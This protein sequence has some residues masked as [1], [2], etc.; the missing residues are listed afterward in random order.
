MKAWA[1]FVQQAAAQEG[2]RPFASLE[3]KLPCRIIDA[4]ELYAI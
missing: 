2:T 1:D 4:G 3:K